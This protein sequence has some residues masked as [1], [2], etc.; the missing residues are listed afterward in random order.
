MQFN[1]FI[2]IG[3]FLAVLGILGY[4]IFFPFTTI[5]GEEFMKYEKDANTGAE[6]FT[7]FDVGDKVTV[8]D[9]IVRMQYGFDAD[10]STSIWVES[11]GKTDQ[12]LRF[13]CDSDY[14]NDFGIGDK[15]VL[16]LEI[17]NNGQSEGFIC[18]ACGRLST[19]FEYASI[20]SIIV[21]I[22]LVIFGFVGGVSKK[23]RPNIIIDRTPIKR[24]K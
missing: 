11:L 5:E 8:Y 4:A 19:P 17:V 15:V 18:E 13:V 6:D 3:A 14:M 12:S 24:A 22:G 2:K 7:N 21:G 1:I 20:G 9:T 10:T 23:I 16:K